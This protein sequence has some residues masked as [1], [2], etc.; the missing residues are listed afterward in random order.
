MRE[1]IQRNEQVKINILAILFFIF[2]AGH[3]SSQK[4]TF[5]WSDTIVKPGQ[6]R[7]IRYWRGELSGPCSI[8]PCYDSFDNKLYY[9][10]LINFLKI[11][12][13][14]KIEIS[15]HTDQRGSPSEK[16]RISGIRSANVVKVLIR[17]GIDGS[18]L[19]SVG[20]GSERPL[21]KQ[22]DIDKKKT[23]VEKEELYAINRRYEITIID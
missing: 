8:G 23:K 2:L 7:F 6:I 3:S 15:A 21:V 20:Y 19:K 1:F 9:D 13:A 11:N 14:I 10:S 16:K 5:E 17:H 4:N 22:A 18:R 12:P